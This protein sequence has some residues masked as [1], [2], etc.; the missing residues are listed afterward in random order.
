[1]KKL[2]IWTA[3]T[4]AMLLGLLLALVWLTTFHTQ[5]ALQAPAFQLSSRIA[6][7]SAHQE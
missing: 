2:V 1:M 4:L 7:P 3:G 5:R 6:P